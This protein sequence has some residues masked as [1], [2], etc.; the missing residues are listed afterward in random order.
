MAPKCASNVCCDSFH[1]SAKLI[2]HV[3]FA[4]TLSGKK[5]KRLRWRNSHWLLRAITRHALSFAHRAIKLC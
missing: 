5:G 3:R 4:I 2:S 1:V